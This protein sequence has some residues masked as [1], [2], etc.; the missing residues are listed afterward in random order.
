[1]ANS[2]FGVMPRWGHRLDPVTIRMLTAYVWSRG[3]G[4][5]AQ[6]ETEA[7]GEDA[8]DPAGEVIAQ[9]ESDERG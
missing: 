6:I 3:G 1:M 2:R 7:E 4:E 8:A 5:G 9:V